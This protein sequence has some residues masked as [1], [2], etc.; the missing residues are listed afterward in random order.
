MR[1]QRVDAGSL[2]SARAR[3]AT[4]AKCVVAMV[5]TVQGRQCRVVERM[6]CRVSSSGTG[7][8][9]S[10]E[11]DDD[12]EGCTQLESLVECRQVASQIW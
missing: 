5:R 9:V 1:R 2:A 12:E 7:A 4:D 8:G 11:Y 10:L 3:Q 6:P